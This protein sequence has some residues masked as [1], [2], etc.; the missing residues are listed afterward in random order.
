MILVWA[1]VTVCVCPLK[2]FLLSVN[3]SLKLKQD[4]YLCFQNDS[5][6]P[7]VTNDMIRLTPAVTSDMTCLTTGVTSYMTHVKTY[8]TS[9]MTLL[10]IDVTNYVTHPDG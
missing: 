1:T 8:V 5:K 9:D 3:E 10:T 7:E 2:F 4:V 6:G